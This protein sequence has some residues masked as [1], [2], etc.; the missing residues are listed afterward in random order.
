MESV[1][2]RLGPRSY[3]IAL[4]TAQPAGVGPFARR[5]LPASTAALVVSDANTASL[6]N[7]VEATLRANGFRT[8]SVTVPAGEGTKSLAELSNLYDALYAMTADRRTAVVA[9]G[10]G[11]VGDLGGFA[12]ATY[13]RGLPLLMVPTTMLAMVDS[14]VG[15]KTGV[16]HPKGKNLIGAFHQPAGVWIDT[17]FLDTLPDR[18]FRSG[19]AEVVKYGVILD[20]PF[21]DDLEANAGDLLAREPATLRHVVGRSCRLKA[22][23]VE[24]DEREETGLRAVL[25]YGH[26]FAHAFETVG[27]YGGWLHGEAVAAGMVC[28]ARLAERHGLIGPVLGQR[29]L[30]LLTKFGLPTASKPEWP[31]DEL[32]AVM[33]R[34]KK[35]AGGNL[36]FILPT[37]LGEVRLF[38]D[39]PEALVRDVLAAP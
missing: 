18:E 13:N 27:G 39:V 33:R 25:N 32:I 26:T 36:R 12:A 1:H 14:S 2:V 5:A 6:A 23:V 10:G 22:D 37:R 21:F 31:M 34:D 20:E 16:N 15:G 38:D 17:A 3:E 28:A 30:A 24:K 8:A 29:Q 11:V 19:L 9:V 35:A 4:T 7:D